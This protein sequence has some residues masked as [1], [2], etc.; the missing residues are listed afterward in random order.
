[1]CFCLP[2]PNP[3]VTLNPWPPGA[4]FPLKD[5]A[6]LSSILGV[7]PSSFFGSIS[8]KPRMCRC[9]KSCWRSAWTTFTWVTVPFSVL[10]FL[11]LLVFVFY[12]AFNST[13]HQVLTPDLFSL[14]PF[15]MASIVFREKY[16]DH[17]GAYYIYALLSTALCFIIPTLGLWRTYGVTSDQVFNGTVYV[18]DNNTLR[19]SNATFVDDLWWRWSNFSIWFC[20][21]MEGIIFLFL[22]VDGIVRAGCKF[23]PDYDEE[24]ETKGDDYGEM[25]PGCGDRCLYLKVPLVAKAD[26]PKAGGF[27]YVMAFLT[28]LFFLLIFCHVLIVLISIGTYTPVWTLNQSSIFLLYSAVAF[29]CNPPLG[30]LTYTFGREVRN[31]WS[32]FFGWIFLA[33]GLPVH[34]WLTAMDFRWI[35]SE[36][37]QVLPGS[38]LDGT[39]CD[40]QT[41]TL[42][43]SFGYECDPQGTFPPLFSGL[44][45]AYQ[46]F[47]MFIAIVAVLFTIGL[48]VWMILIG[49]DGDFRN[50]I[51]KSGI[52]KY[53]KRKEQ[54]GAY[55]VV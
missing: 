49:S 14:V 55:Q 3:S 34:L 1:M 4:A 24:I 48:F 18:Y 45:F 39:T 31:R 29:L 42:G 15:S 52:V 27:I 38:I 21:F 43:P 11:V 36:G 26:I 8:Q 16:H 54:Y 2:H 35:I 47:M 23:H 22:V 25:I 10:T 20:I 53:L 32:M 13:P 41:D 17:M 46:F 5:S 44:T 28:G 37:N 40:P 19:I 51:S 9:R 30:Q 6:T 12:S 50:T 33:I 7:I